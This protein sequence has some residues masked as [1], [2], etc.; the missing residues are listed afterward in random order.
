MLTKAKLLDILQIFYPEVLVPSTVATEIRQYG[1]TDV[2]FQSLI[3]TEWLVIVETPSVPESVRAFNL[4]PGESAVLAWAHSH[5]D[6]EAIL[7][8]LAARR[9]ADSLGI[10]VRGTLG[11]VLKAKQQ[12][13]IPSARSILEQLRQSGMYLSERVLNQSLELVGE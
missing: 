3:Q 1:T 2:T 11:L 9:C 6:T 7:D 4:D 8:D 12:G 5:P 10:P 13:K